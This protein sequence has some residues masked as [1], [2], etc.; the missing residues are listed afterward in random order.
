MELFFFNLKFFETHLSTTLGTKSTY[1]FVS[2]VHRFSLFDESLDLKFFFK[3][4]APLMTTPVAQF[5]AKAT[6]FFW[7]HLF[8]GCCSW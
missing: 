1:N 6:D 4:F 5:A 7:F 8:F 2:N 3:I